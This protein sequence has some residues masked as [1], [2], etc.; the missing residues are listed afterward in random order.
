MLRRRLK[1]A[2]EKNSKLKLPYDS[3]RV[4][5]DKLDSIIQT[6]PYDSERVVIDKLDSII[7]TKFELGS[8]FSEVTCG[9]KEMLE[10]MQIPVPSESP[11]NQD[12]DEDELADSVDEKEKEIESIEALSDY[13]RLN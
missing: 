2:M 5:I 12:I 3:E 10:A 9:L 6:L 1:L 8:Y 4:V 13:C 11:D 7:Q